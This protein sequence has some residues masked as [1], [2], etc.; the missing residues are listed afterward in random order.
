MSLL[1][2]TLEDQPTNENTL[3]GIIQGAIKTG[4]LI[5]QERQKNSIMLQ[6]IREIREMME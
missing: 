2:R 3:R 6:E 5:E 4:I 1:L